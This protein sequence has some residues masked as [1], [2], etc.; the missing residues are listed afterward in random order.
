MLM[1][2]NNKLKL[3][4]Y[5]CRSDPLRRLW[6]SWREADL[7]LEKCRLDSLP[8]V[9]HVVLCPWGIFLLKF[10][11]VWTTEWCTFHHQ[12]TN[13]TYLLSNLDDCL[14][15]VLGLHTMAVVAHL[16]LNDK[17][18]HKHLLQDG[19][20]HHLERKTL[21]GKQI[22]C[23][24]ILCFKLFIYQTIREEDKKGKSNKKVFHQHKQRSWHQ[25][26]WWLKFSVKVK[27]MR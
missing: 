3:V 23:I 18:H 4:S 10:I 6:Y 7:W 27:V 5:I 19:A 22:S 11:I 20:V 15:E 13:I 17:L 2:T 14:P 1:E 16:G 25:E 26:A 24:Q 21:N 9:S 8:Y 12:K